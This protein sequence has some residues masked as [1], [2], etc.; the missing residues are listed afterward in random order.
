MLR[1][2]LRSAR[3][4]K[5]SKVVVALLTPLIQGSRLRLTA[6][7]ENAWLDPYLLGF[8][9]MLITMLARAEQ[10]RLSDSELCAVQAKAWGELTDMNADLFGEEVTLLAETRDDRFLS[11]CRDAENVVAL[12]PVTGLTR[13]NEMFDFEINTQIEPFGSATKIWELTFDHR[14]VSLLAETPSVF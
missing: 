11:G 4:R 14:M 7:P 8:M 1:W 3:T 6:F 9:A 2:A 10:R 5:T 13:Q 12:L